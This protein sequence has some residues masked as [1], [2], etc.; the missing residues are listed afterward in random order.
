MEKLT[1]S[2][3]SQKA[4]ELFMQKGY[5][6]VTIVDICEQCHITKPTFYKYVGSKEDLI[7]DLYDSIIDSLII[8]AYQ[9]LEIESHFEQLLLIF[10]TLLNT[11]EKYGSDLFSHMLSS[12]LKKDNH[13]FD[14]R[15]N[16]TKLCVLII[17]KGQAAGEFRNKNDAGILYRTIAYAFTGY[18]CMWCIKNGS[19]DLKNE[20]IESLEAILDAR[21][22]LRRTDAT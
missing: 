3:I 4:I 12:N 6:Q 22:D 8:D 5:D 9:I 19:L 10:N 18:E 2:K 21:S 11:T 20:F 1:R 13:S 15:D 17:K 7:L 16:L 14:M